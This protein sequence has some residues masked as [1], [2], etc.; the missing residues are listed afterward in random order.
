MK[1][2]LYQTLVL[3]LWY[4]LSGHATGTCGVEEVA[5]RIKNR[6]G[7]YVVPMRIIANDRN[8]NCLQLPP[9]QEIMCTSAGWRDGGDQETSAIGYTNN[10]L[11]RGINLLQIAK[12]TVH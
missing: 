8:T 1:D 12:S 4:Q 9:W 7:I 11:T 10:L 3:L 6:H 2:I 5:K